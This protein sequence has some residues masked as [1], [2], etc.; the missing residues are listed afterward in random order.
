MRCTQ[1]WLIA[2]KK[3]AGSLLT[4]ERWR[5]LDIDSSGVV[6]FEEWVHAFST[7]VTA[8]DDEDEDDE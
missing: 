7:W 1:P 3:D 6:D 5:E 2:G 4:A 8:G